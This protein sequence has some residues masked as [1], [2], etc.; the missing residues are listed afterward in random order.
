MKLG[1]NN[2]ACIFIHKKILTTQDESKLM[3]KQMEHALD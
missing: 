2:K 3:I 1:K